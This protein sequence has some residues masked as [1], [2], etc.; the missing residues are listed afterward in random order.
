M[1]SVNVNLHDCYSN[2]VFYKTLHCLMWVNFRLGWLDTTFS[3][4]FYN[5]N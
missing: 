4:L 1:N 2:C 5:K 3:Q